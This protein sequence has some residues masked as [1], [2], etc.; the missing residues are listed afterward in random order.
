M[1]FRSFDGQPK[2]LRLYGHGRVVTRGSHEWA[3]LLA[4]FPALPG[5]RQIVVCDVQQVQTSCGF[6][7][8]LMSLVAQRDLLTT[9]AEARGDEGLVEYRR[10]RNA[11]SLDGLLTPPTDAA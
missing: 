1:L 7:V 2:I 3:P 10:T 4:L 11:V 5:V 6:A 9:W 8:P